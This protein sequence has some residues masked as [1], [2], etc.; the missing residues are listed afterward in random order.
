M[1]FLSD[2]QTSTTKSTYAPLDLA[3]T[4]LAE[5]SCRLRWTIWRKNVLLSH[6]F[7]FQMGW[8]AWDEFYYI[9]PSKLLKFYVNY[10]LPSAYQNN[11]SQIMEQ[12]TSEESVKFIQSNEICH[13]RCSP[14]H[15]SSNS[16]VER[17]VRSFKEAMK[18]SRNDELSLRHRLI[19]YCATV[20]CLKLQPDN[21]PAPSFW[22]VLF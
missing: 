10:F 8:S 19:F 6:W 11:L 15:L 12:F 18:A 22:A 7:A 21:L 13:I 5:S 20:L 14:Y 3:F 16:L 4:P 17:F 9:Q 1:L 2:N